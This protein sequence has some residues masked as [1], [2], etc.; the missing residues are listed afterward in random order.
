MRNFR[1][2]ISMDISRFT[3]SVW[4][5]PSLSNDLLR[6][7]LMNLW[8]NTSKSTAPYHSTYH[9]QI[10]AVLSVLLISGWNSCGDMFRVENFQ[11]LGA[12]AALQVLKRELSTS[13]LQPWVW[14]TVACPWLASRH[15]GRSMPWNS[16]SKLGNWGCQKRNS[17]CQR[18]QHSELGWAVQSM[19]SSLEPTLHPESQT[20]HCFRFFCV[21]GMLRGN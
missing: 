2:W 7:V 3:S 9:L 10:E 17:C 21:P 18:C 4:V 8:Q 5:I 14:T 16:P 1:F 19:Q 15:G 11:E 20:V 6:W 12:D 13:L